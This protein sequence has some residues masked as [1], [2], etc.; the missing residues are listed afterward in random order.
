[1]VGIRVYLT[2]GQVPVGRDSWMFGQ[3]AGKDIDYD[4]DNVR[5]VLTDGGTLIRRACFRFM[6][7]LRRQFL[8]LRATRTIREAVGYVKRLRRVIR[9]RQALVR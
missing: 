7:R 8:L 2:D 5:F 6:N 4:D 3:F 1:M 9:R